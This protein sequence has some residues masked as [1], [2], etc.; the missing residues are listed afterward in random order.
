MATIVPSAFV[1]AS[2]K[3]YIRRELLSSEPKPA[4][5]KMSG[6]KYITVLIPQNYCQNCKPPPIRMHVPYIAKSIFTL[7]KKGS[8]LSCLMLSTS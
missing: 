2:G 3:L 5:C 4:F 7:V 1:S 8:L 6:P